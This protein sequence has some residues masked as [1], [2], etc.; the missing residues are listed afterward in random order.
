M[1]LV[2]GPQRGEGGA[3]WAAEIER[4][5]AR[6]RAVVLAHN[7]QPAAIQDVADHVGDSLALARLA[8][9]TDAEVIVFAGVVFMAETAKIL[10]PAKTVLIPDPGAGCSL[11]DGITAGQV[12]AWKAEHPGAAVVAY[13]NTSAEVKAEADVCCTSANAIEVVAAIPAER[14]VLFLPDQFLGSY[15]Q[16]ALGRDNMHVWLGECH[17]HAGISPD[18]L[19]SAVADDPDAAL[20]IHPECG[21]T[22]SALW[23]AGTG[24]LP[25]GRTRVLSTGG[26]ARRRARG[27]GPPGAGRHRDRHA[28]PATQGQPAGAVGPGGRPGRVPLHEDD[29]PRGP[30]GR[31]ARRD[32][33][34]HRRPGRGRAGPTG[35]GSHDRRRPPRGRRVTGPVVRDLPALPVADED[36]ATVVVVGAG[37][38][39]ASAAL[40][41]A[42]AGADV[43]VLRKGDGSTRWAQGGLAA[44]VG[45]GDSAAEH[46][47]D[48]AAAGAGLC[49]DD[50][51][52]TVVE[53]APA[54][55]DRLVALGGRFDTARLGLEGGHSHHRIVHAGGD[56]SG[57]E[58]QRV[59]DAGLAAAC[60]TGRLRVRHGAVAL[61]AVLDRA[62]RVT[63]VLVGATPAGGGPLTVTL[64][65]TAALVLATGGIGH[66]YATTTNPAAVTGDGLALAARAG[67]E[68]TD[69]EFVQFHPTVLWLAGGRG[70]RPLVTEA[71]RGAG[72]LL[73]DGDGRRVMAGA[74]PGGDLAPR[75]VVSATMARRMA[76]LGVPHLWLDARGVGRARLEAGFPTVTAACR[77]H[78]IDPVEQP[79]PVAPGHHYACGGVRA[80]LDGTTSVPGLLAVGEVA[81]TGLHG[82]NRL[83]S[84]SITESL[85]AGRR[86]GRRL[87]RLAASGD[88]RPPTGPDPDLP[89]PGTGA[90]PAARHARADAMARHAGVL[91]HGDGLEHL[92]ALL[93][94][95]PPGPAAADAASVESANLHLVSLLVATAATARTESRG[96][97]QRS[98][99]PH[100]DE[101]WERRV[102]LRRRGA[103]LDVAVG[104]TPGGR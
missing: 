96:S 23:L 27:D 76:T 81:A 104:A 19:R 53:S 62:G 55:I 42:A 74:H 35:G 37:A 57:A 31:P 29:D 33:R 91:R 79:I 17:V 9:A 32:H 20:Y 65:R 60:G 86:A 38:A 7:Y 18:D 87:G 78:G 83:A 43:L 70:R 25:A 95:E 16:R 1:A 90:A 47:A 61:D 67:A 71:L 56:A 3:G 24:D 98:D 80:D 2:V 48:T 46:A 4:L 93:A 49:D 92:A 26:N 77:T 41:A 103:S 73:V 94:A 68:V 69:V 72:A 15:V 44:A 84:N 11:A 75:D 100:R 10:S 52:A 85:V 51:V 6:R 58:V 63:G 64:V 97:H 8:A 99:F 30:A 54:E 21:C 28:P 14:E 88:L 50:A 22:T 36:A 59:L 40:E 101:A 13:V 34:G 66:A 45:P 12:R 5:K 102:I 39:G 82:A 89:L